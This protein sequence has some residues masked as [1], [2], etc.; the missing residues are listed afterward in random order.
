[1]SLE[2]WAAMPEDEPG[3]LVDGHL[4]EEEVANFTHEGIVSAL[5]ATIRVW[6]VPRGGLVFGSGGKFALGPGHGRKPDVSVFLPGGAVPPREGAASAPP[7][8]LIEVIAPTAADARRDRIEKA[9][10]YAAFGVRSLWLIDP[11][12]G[13]RTL[14][15]H[16]L[17]AGRRYGRVLFAST[18]V[19][20]VP[21][22]PDLRLDLDALGAEVD[23]L[24][25]PATAAR[26]RQER[27]KGPARR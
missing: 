27:A 17:D 19:V 25:P 3:E 8:L 6:A 22:C 20:D 1:M 15:I 18:G 26:R 9:V 11:N 21:G 4:V 24:G 2:A 14:E 10:A 13:A 12:P 7:D 23:R 16:E 5:S